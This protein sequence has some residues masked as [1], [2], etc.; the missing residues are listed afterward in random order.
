MTIRGKIEYFWVIT[1]ITAGVLF[2]LLFNPTSV[3]AQ[4][5]SQRKLAFQHY[6]NKQFRSAA[7]VLSEY[8]P[9]HPKDQEALYRWPTAYIIAMILT[10]RSNNF[11]N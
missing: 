1:S 8:C 5:K 6:E 11:N 3:R 2:I 10:E 7:L 9:T 4:E